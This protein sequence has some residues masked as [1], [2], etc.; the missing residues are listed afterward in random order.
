MNRMHYITT[1]V[2]LFTIFNND[3]KHLKD[4]V[5]KEN[6]IL[7]YQNQ[8]EEITLG[9]SFKDNDF[10]V[11]EVELSTTEQDLSE[12]LAYLKKQRLSR[13]STEKSLSM[14][15]GKEHTQENALLESKEVVN[16]TAGTTMSIKNS[17]LKSPF[18]TLSSPLFE[19]ENC[20]LENVSTLIL[21]TKS[22]T[23]LIKKIQFTFS[24][25]PFVTPFIEGNLNLEKGL[26]KTD[27]FIIRGIK[28]IE[29]QFNESVLN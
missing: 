9:L 13:I 25:N 24:K 1:F 2:L 3:G 28:N 21:E 23:A 14:G 5:T 26:V 4:I 12:Y 29:I 10:K 17:I 20:F 19:I 15:S 16:L 8:K 6:P 11:G 22:S 7:S 27:Y 18:I